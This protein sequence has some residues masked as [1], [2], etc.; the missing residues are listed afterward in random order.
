MR[1]ALDGRTVFVGTGGRADAQAVGPA[2]SGGH[3]DARASGHGDAIASGVAA[4][5]MRSPNE[6][7]KAVV[8][9][10]GAAHDHTVWVMPARYFARHGYRV[11]APDLPG[12]GRSEGPALES[13]E[14]SADWLARVLDALS[15]ESAAVVGHSMGA[16]VAQ[17][18]ATRH[19]PRVRALAL[20]GTSVPMPV[21]ERLLTA[22][23]RNDHAA[24]DMANG[25]S[26]SARAR[27][28]G[29]PNP[30]VWML[31]AG[32][33]LIE[34]TPPG[35][36]HADLA[37]CNAYRADPSAIAAPTLVIVGEQ[38]QMTPPRAGRDVA[39][40]IPNAR[41]VTLAGSGHA[42]LSEQPNQVLDAL[43]SIV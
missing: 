15:V 18:F 40:K 41:I 11:I 23:Q 33:R 43:A 31:G 21:T 20:L 2:E 39:A 35:V 16:L 30:G 9:I 3:D 17:A 7:T 34:R 12:H 6:V 24:T 10:H 42:M 26:H 25:W 29:S 5:E 14:G 19:P 36:H 13:I 38:D 28:G 37:A 27:L 22:A 8:F 4:T 1:I 32:E